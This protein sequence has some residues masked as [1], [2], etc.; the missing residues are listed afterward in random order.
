MR[1]GG[2]KL[3]WYQFLDHA[4]HLRQVSEIDCCHDLNMVLLRLSEVMLAITLCA[5]TQISNHGSLQAC[6]RV[7]FPTWRMTSSCLQNCVFLS[8]S[9][10]LA[11]GPACED[12]ASVSSWVFSIFSASGLA[13]EHSAG[14]SLESF[15]HILL[16]GYSFWRCRRCVSWIFS[17]LFASGLAVEDRADASSWV[18]S[19]F[20]ASK[21]A[22]EVSGSM[23]SW[24]KSQD[25]YTTLE[26]SLHAR[27]MLHGKL[28]WSCNRHNLAKICG[29]GLHCLTCYIVTITL[30]FRL[31][32][33][34]DLAHWSILP[35]SHSG[36]W[37]RIKRTNEINAKNL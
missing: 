14:V 24:G 11:S 23:P 6:C 25:R 30:T 4:F 27:R 31:T 26:A 15:Q 13:F 16:P 5:S 1:A 29:R 35:K 12:S 36:L 18:F 28:L 7:P 2:C 17:T 21:L 32:T 34:E 37:E 10:F 20:P 9:T 22:S 8:L 19:T 33:C 3:Q